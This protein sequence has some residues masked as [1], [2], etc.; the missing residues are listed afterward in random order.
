[1]FLN[2]MMF[3]FLILF[4]FGL[5]FINNI[6]IVLGL[7]FIFFILQ[8]IFKIKLPLVLPFIIFLLINFLMNYF[9]S[10]LLDA[11][12]VTL[13]LIIMFI[14]VNIFIQKVGI[15]M[16]GKIIGKI[17]HSKSLELIISISL[18][19]I[20]IMIKEIKNIKDSLKTKNFSF[21][22]K[23]MI[24]RPHIFVITFFNNLFRRVNEMEKVFL[25]RGVDE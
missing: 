19:F 3:I 12:L 10:S 13:R 22:L 14:I 15:M 4:S 11:T 6:Y 20:P 18:S 7:F 16:I 9:L 25:S 5:F 24:T 17:F 8:I 2:S 1:M 23:N 21:N